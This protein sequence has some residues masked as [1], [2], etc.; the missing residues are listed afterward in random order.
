MSAGLLA[1][2]VTP[3]SMAPELSVTTP[4]SRPRSSWASVGAAERMSRM[5][6]AGAIAIA[7]LG[8][9]DGRHLER[10][11]SAGVA[12]QDLFGA[13]E[14]LVRPSPRQADGGQEAAGLGIAG[15]YFL[16]APGQGLGGVHVSG[17]F[18]HLGAQ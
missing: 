1:V 4:V 16:R 9:R 14:R 10:T 11:R 2:I 3:G 8:P 15:R 5:R 12:G 17:R 7:L 18:L 13:A 6:I